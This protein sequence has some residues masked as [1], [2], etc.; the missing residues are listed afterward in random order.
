MATNRY[1]TKVYPFS[2][3]GMMEMS[4][5]FTFMRDNLKRI[6]PIFIERSLDYLEERAKENIDKTTGGASWYQ[7][8]GTLKDSFVKDASVGTL[9]NTCFYSAFVEYGT[10]VVG[11]GTHPNPNGY[12]YDA[13]NHGGNG[14]FYY[15]DEGNIHWTKGMKAHRY[16]Y[17]AINDYYYKGAW[18]KIL[19]GI[20]DEMM[21][22]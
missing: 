18:K 7:I 14:W 12:Q 17:D 11:A 22:G 8:T 4:E 6:K 1:N 20:M 13:N 5:Y 3:K 21:G 19:K 10:G 16:M 15:D 9:I 2:V